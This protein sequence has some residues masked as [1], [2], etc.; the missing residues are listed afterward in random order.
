MNG[1]ESERPRDQ[2]C[3]L[4]RLGRCWLVL[5]ASEL[6]RLLLQLLSRPYL[7]PFACLPN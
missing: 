4:R 7:T 3:H 6:T 5:S 2:T 1:E